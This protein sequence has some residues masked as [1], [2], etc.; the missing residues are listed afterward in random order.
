MTDEKKLATPELSDD[1]SESEWK[2]FYESRNAETGLTI[3]LNKL[4]DEKRIPPLI[5]FSFRLG[6]KVDNGKGGQFIP[7]RVRGK[8]GS[9]EIH[10]WANEVMNLIYEAEEQA[11]LYFEKK[12]SENGGSSEK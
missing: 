10:S 6:R 4:E 11:L 5:L 7:V 12:D 3:Q 2:L 1:K 8:K 9:R